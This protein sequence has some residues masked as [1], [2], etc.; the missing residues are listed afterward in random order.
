MVPKHFLFQNS[1]VSPFNDLAGFVGADWPS[2][3]RYME[4][5]DGSFMT[6][7]IFVDKI[8][9]TFSS[10]YGGGEKRDCFQLGSNGNIEGCGG[11]GAV[12][13]EITLYK[14]T[15]ICLNND[16]LSSVTLNSSTELSVPTEVCLNPFLTSLV[17]MGYLLNPILHGGR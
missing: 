3:T 11:N 17:P 7:G 1:L 2:E 16:F 8:D 12:L 13:C 5:Q 10:L 4:Y 15:H 6:D 14:D 9:T